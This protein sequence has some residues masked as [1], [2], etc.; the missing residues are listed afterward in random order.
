MRLLDIIQAYFSGNLVVVI[1]EDNKKYSY[2]KGGNVDNRF[3]LSSFAEI[4]KLNIN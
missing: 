4:I 1:K 2:V 3:I